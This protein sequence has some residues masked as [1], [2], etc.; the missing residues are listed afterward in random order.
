MFFKVIRTSDEEDIFLAQKP[1]NV[2][3]FGSEVLMMEWKEGRYREQKSM[4]LPQGVNVFSANITDVD[5]DGETDIVFVDE[6]DSRLK[7]VSTNA[8]LIWESSSCFT[9]ATKYLNCPLKEQFPDKPAPPTKKKFIGPRLI[10]SEIPGDNIE[11][12]LC[13]NYL[14]LNKGEIL[15]LTR[16]GT[17]FIEH[18]KTKKLQGCIVDYQLKDTDNDGRKELVIAVVL[19]CTDSISTYQSRLLIHNLRSH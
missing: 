15:G 7:A 3:G 12:I 17:T 14:N 1:D 13:R 11:I 8:E 18:W 2:R 19:N 5:M 16:D 6:R 4:Q 9:G 10:V